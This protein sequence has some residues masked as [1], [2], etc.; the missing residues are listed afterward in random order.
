MGQRIPLH[1]VT[2]EARLSKEGKYELP[3]LSH[4]FEYKQI[5]GAKAPLNETPR[6]RGRGI[7]PL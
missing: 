6:R 4:E 1:K 2:L 3:K 5:H 7:I